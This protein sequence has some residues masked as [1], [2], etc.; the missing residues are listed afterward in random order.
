MLH[1]MKSLPSAWCYLSKIIHVFWK[2]AKIT[3]SVPRA[4]LIADDYS[5]IVSTAPVCSVNCWAHYNIKVPYDAGKYI[6]NSD[7]MGI[8]QSE[9]LL[10]FSASL[11][12]T[13]DVLT[14]ERRNFDRTIMYIWGFS[15]FTYYALIS[16]FLWKK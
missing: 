11:H 10:Y 13:L 6:G 14:S 9:N 2:F 3:I 16:I 7:W 4:S 15:H 5:P 8:I 1:E 12:L